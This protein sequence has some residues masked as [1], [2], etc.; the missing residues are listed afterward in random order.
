MRRAATSTLVIFRHG[1]G[2]A[3]TTTKLETWWWNQFGEK[4]KDEH[5]F[6]SITQAVVVH[7][8]VPSGLEEMTELDGNAS[9]FEE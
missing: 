4:D 8:S 7:G 9:G 5:E 6:V 2:T 1:G 3:G